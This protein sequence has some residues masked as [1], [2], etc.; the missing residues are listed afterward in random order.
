L[1]ASA[2]TLGL[3]VSLA[4]LVLVVFAPSAHAGVTQTLGFGSAVES[5][6]RHASFDSLRYGSLLRGYTENGLIIDQAGGCYCSGFHYNSTFEPTK[7]SAADGQKL[8]A[9][10]FGAQLQSEIPYSSILYWEAHDDGALVGS[11]LFFAPSHSV[12]GFFDPAGF[13]DLQITGYTRL[14]EA[15][16]VAAGGFAG[17]TAHG[18]IEIDNLFAEVAVDADGDGRLGRFDNCPNAP[19]PDQADADLDGEGDACDRF[20]NG[21]SDLDQCLDDLDALRRDPRLSD[22]DGDGEEDA[23]D[24]CPET[25]AASEVDESGCSLDQFCSAI[26]ASGWRGRMVCARADWRNDD[27]PH[28]WASDCRVVHGVCVAR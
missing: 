4:L 10:E 3:R 15:Q 27:P 28:R 11:G 12:V 20:P 26:D 5:F 13:D 19:N 1:T 25:E 6:D 18:G 23:S 16:R 2:R 8:V 17:T 9:L 21:G 14:S 7:I 24:L 22:S